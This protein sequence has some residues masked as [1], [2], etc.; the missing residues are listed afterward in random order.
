MATYTRKN[1]T[2]QAY[3]IFA[4]FIAIT[5]FFIVPQFTGYFTGENWIRVDVQ[6]RKN[7]P[8][9]ISNTLIQTDSISHSRLIAYPDFKLEIQPGSSWGIYFLV[10][11]LS[12]FVFAFISLWYILKAIKN[13]Q[14]E[15]SFEQTTFEAIYKIGRILIFAGIVI[16]LDKYFLNWYLLKTL[17]Y[18]FYKVPSGGGIYLFFG[19][20]SIY[21]SRYYRRGILLQTESELTV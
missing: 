11:E 8:V 20:L 12:G 1:A 18:S 2:R 21:F 17:G 7:A 19:A 4:A 5:L 6:K 13:M 3:I 14:S 10:R 15:D 16:Y 9:R